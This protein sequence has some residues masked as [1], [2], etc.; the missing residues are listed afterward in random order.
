LDNLAA[1]RKFVA[2]HPDPTEA[3][4]LQAELRALK[5]RARELDV[6]ADTNNTALLRARIARAEAKIA[7]E[8]AR[9]AAKG[10][11]M[12]RDGVHAEH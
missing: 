8:A 6:F 10:A 12:L 7:N 5:Q 4:R 11:A 9:L 3:E 2:E 1:A